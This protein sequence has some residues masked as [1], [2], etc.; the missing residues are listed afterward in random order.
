MTTDIV[1][2]VQCRSVV[3]GIGEEVEIDVAWGTLANPAVG[4]EQCRFGVLNH[5]NTILTIVSMPKSME[6]WEGITLER[7][8]SQSA[9][10]PSMKSR[11]LVVP[12]K[13]DIS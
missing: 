6:R 1:Q 3:F 13:F 7:T 8:P 12:P 5:S 10:R 9:V 4:L 2:R 11:V